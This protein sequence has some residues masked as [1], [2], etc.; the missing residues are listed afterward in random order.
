MGVEGVNHGFFVVVVVVMSLTSSRKRSSSCI[1][2][3]MFMFIFM[4]MLVLALVQ[5]VLV[6]CCTHRDAI[7]ECWK[8]RR[9]GEEGEEGVGAAESGFVIGIGIGIFII[10]AIIFI[11]VGVGVVVVIEFVLCYG[12]GVIGAVGIG[13]SSSIGS[14]SGSRS[15]KSDC[16]VG[17]RRAPE[18]AE[19]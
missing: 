3:F 6:R 13:C 7:V 11:G 8:N 2:K 14:V 12:D 15:S 4:S 16:I 17:H 5:L 1:F 18:R 9:G 10:I 19:H